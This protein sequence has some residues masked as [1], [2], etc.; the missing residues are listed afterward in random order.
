MKYQISTLDLTA[1][2]NSLSAGFVYLTTD[3]TIG[4]CNES[5]AAL[6]NSAPVEMTGSKLTDHPVQF[7]SEQGTVLS[8]KKNPI[9]LACKANKPQ[10]DQL[11]HIRINA[12][13]EAWIRCNIEPIYDMTIDNF[14]GA[15]LSFVEVTDAILAKREQK[16]TE[17]KY[18][19]HF[20]FSE[21]A[22]F[23]ATKDGRYLGVSKGAEKMFGYT[24]AELKKIGRKGILIEDEAFKKTVAE[25]DKKG[26]AITEVKG[27]R[28]DGTVFPV[29]WY[30]TVFT[31]TS[32]DELVSVAMI[33]LSEKK[34]L[35][36]SAQK[37]DYN[38]Q[39]ILDNT[40][41]AFVLLDENCKVLTF[42]KTAV[43]TFKEIHNKEL[44]P[45][46]N[47]RQLFNKIHR[48]ELDETLTEVV[49]GFS[50]DMQRVFHLPDGGLK[51]FQSTFRPLHKNDKVVGIIINSKDTT[52]KY[53]IQQELL[54]SHERYKRAALASFDILWEH[55]L[56]EK[57]IYFSDTFGQAFGYENH[58]SIISASEFSEKFIHADDRL[59]VLTS[60]S[61]FIESKDIYFTYPVHRLLKKDGSFIYAEA[62]VI[63]S[64]DEDGQAY[65]L[66]GVTR[67]ITSRYLMETQ[68][69]ESNERYHH[70][71]RATSDV[72]WDWNL[73]TNYNWISENFFLQYGYKDFG[74]DLQSWKEK[75]HPDDCTR[76]LASLTNALKG[77]QAVWEEE[78]R[79]LKADGNYATVYNRGYVLYDD[80]GTAY[81]MIGALQDITNL[82]NL[83]Q[84]IIEEQIGLQRKITE[85]TIKSQE[86]DREEL[87]KELHDNINQILA[88]CKMLIDVSIK[89]EEM[90]DEFLPKSYDYL[91]RA[92]EEI[93]LLSK[94][95][96]PPSLGDI[97]LSEALE[98][99]VQSQSGA[100]NI[101]FHLTG[102]VIK[103]KVVANDIQLMAYRI[104]QEQLNNILKYA[105]ATQVTIHLSIIKQILHIEVT[106]NGIGFDAKEKKKGIG[107][108]NMKSR[109]QLYGGEVKIIS[110]PGNGCTL[111]VC[112]PVG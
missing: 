110:S 45:G 57:K 52:R 34:Q 44:K 74:S 5:A 97:G 70:V 9:L 60:V 78:Y 104:I 69:R 11:F 105:K 6:F 62:Q 91:N 95:L 92:I 18:R 66:T 53:K 73:R 35:E 29:L 46:K 10:L 87:G 106:D 55:D 77:D 28:K 48:K 21:G 41:E 12:Q 107:L 31:T 84:K 38:L 42:N 65:L 19:H 37:L 32:G 81:R 64:R 27:R 23:L 89:N 51:V 102:D 3:E 2:F 61:G 101:S 72:V 90:R 88:T 98:E 13:K 14:A 25:R 86:A 103:C 83:Q 99:L 56:Q 15:V 63:A 108:R 1:L 75:L 100:N 49:A 26:K 85:A 94:S 68:L 33:D 24:S 4:Y 80:Q 7:L 71:S 17:E 50:R 93:R 82:K 47:I 54:E 40:D 36:H 112:I 67:D 58:S 111:V 20:T 43:Q 30:A 8:A 76:V 39:L 16:E 22:T 59:M 96:V 109:A 79:M